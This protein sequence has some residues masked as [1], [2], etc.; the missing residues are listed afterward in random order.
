MLCIFFFFFPSD[1]FDCSVSMV[2][3][4]FLGLGVVALASYVLNHDCSCRSLS[5]ASVAFIQAELDCIRF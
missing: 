4:A 5:M 1:C 3:K 2:G